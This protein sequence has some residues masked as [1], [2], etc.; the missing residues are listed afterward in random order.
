MYLIEESL[1]VVG[2]VAILGAALFVAGAL[3]VV[4]HA[5]TRVL[6]QRARQAALQAAAA[7]AE[8]EA[9]VLAQTVRQ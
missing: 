3:V 9:H 4:V 1:A 8:L 5:C 7:L 2:V 6:S